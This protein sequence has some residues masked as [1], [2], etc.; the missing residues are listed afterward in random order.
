M[1]FGPVETLYHILYI[2]ED[3]YVNSRNATLSHKDQ[4]TQLVAK[5]D[6]QATILRRVQITGPYQDHK[7]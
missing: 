6:W 2:Y 4:G 5:L 1:K 7:F 3:V